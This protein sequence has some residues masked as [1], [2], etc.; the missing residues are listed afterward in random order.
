M[1]ACFL[2]QSKLRRSRLVAMVTYAE[3]TWGCFG[4]GV[5]GVAEVEVLALEV[6]ELG[7]PVDPQNGGLHPLSE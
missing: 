3:R 1:V 6:A 2:I 7:V 4:G 5:S